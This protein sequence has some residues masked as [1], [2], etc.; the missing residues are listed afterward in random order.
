MRRNVFELTVLGHRLRIATENDEEYVRTLT[1]Y[2]TS[3]INKLR[4][5][6]RS[7]GNVELLILTTLTLADEV[8]K[9]RK[10]LEETKVRVEKLKTLIDE[11]VKVSQG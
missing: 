10:E 7:V 2:V 8:L 3:C 9:A 4:D 1:E 11:R 5:G 6:N